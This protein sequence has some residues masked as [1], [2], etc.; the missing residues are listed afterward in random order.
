[1][2]RLGRYTKS[3]VKQLAYLLVVPALKMIYFV[4]NRIPRPAANVLTVVDSYLPVIPMF[5]VPYILFYPFV[6]TGLIY[7]FKHNRPAYV[8]TVWCYSIGLVLCYATYWLYQTTFPRPE[9]LGQ[10]IFSYL[11]RQIYQADKPVNCLPSI[12]ALGTMLVMLGLAAGP[13]QKKLLVNFVGVLII[14]S[15]MFTKQHGVLDVIAAL[16]LGGAIYY[17]TRTYMSPIAPSQTRRA[18]VG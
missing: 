16:I 3:D 14:L 9:L 6:F 11:L 18:A 15:T 5:V 1:M 2:L 10:D 13:H 8:H 12:H 7:L 17:I 4:I